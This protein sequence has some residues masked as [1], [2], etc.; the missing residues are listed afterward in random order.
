[1]DTIAES[2]EASA[3]L[4]HILSDLLKLACENTAAEAGFVS[5]VEASTGDLVIMRSYGTAHKDM[6][7]GGRV[8]HGMGIS[9]WTI[10]HRK[11]ALVTDAAS[12]ARFTFKRSDDPGFAL[13]DLVC[14]PLISRDSAIGVLMLLNKKGGAFT[15]ANARLLESVGSLAASAIENAKLYKAENVRRRLAQ[16]LSAFS[17][18]I[19]KSPEIKIVLTVLLDYL[20]QI[21]PCDNAAA[22]L[23]EWDS[24]LAVRA[25]RGSDGTEILAPGSLATFDASAISVLRELLDEQKGKVVRDIRAYPAWTGYPFVGDTRSWLGVPLVA[26]NRVIGMYCLTKNTPGFYGES[27]L[28]L[29]ETLASQTAA[30]I[31]SAW[32]FEKVAEGR[33]HLQSLS[34]QLVEAQEKERASVSR[35]LHDE[36]GQSLTALKVGLHLLEKK[37]G[38][39]AAVKAS[40][41]ALNKQVEGIMVALHRL[42]SNLRPA[43]LDHVGLE[44]AVRQM[45]DALGGQDGPKVE[46]EGGQLRT[47]RLPEFT[48]TQLY[49]I[50]QEAVSNAM[51]H[52]RATSVSVFLGRRDGLIVAI[53]EDDGIGF[54]P[55][56]AFHGGR[57]GLVGMRE[58]AEMLGGKLV[59]ESVEG[60]GTTIFAEVPDADPDTAR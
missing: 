3:E 13:R 40:A 28:E 39:P 11:T 36:A 51:R 4:E 49:R 12:D 38:D 34:R 55:V 19:T 44:A 14:V 9:G 31:Q 30:A 45:V 1:M 6:I 7:A 15:E 10:A 54:D 22:M 21:V 29:A 59:I 58:R 24:R 32:L 37:A 25:V 56:L 57:L 42:A 35:E 52:S 43:S 27:H 41:A 53:I 20:G 48:E 2:P 60:K 23:V 33:A 16:T 26:N 8:A 47:T 18:D 50:V 46:F 17:M 5:L